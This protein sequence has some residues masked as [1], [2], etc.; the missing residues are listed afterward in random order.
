[1]DQL[2]PYRIEVTAHNKEWPRDVLVSLESPIADYICDSFSV[3]LRGFIARCRGATL[4]R[5]RSLKFLAGGTPLASCQINLPRPD[6][7]APKAKT[8]VDRRDSDCGFDTV[9]PSFLT[10]R[11]VPIEIRVEHE[12]DATGSSLEYRLVSIRFRSYGKRRKPRKCDDIGFVIVNSIGRSGSSLVCRVLDQ[13]AAC[14]TPRLGG[15]YGEVFILGHYLRAIGVLSS[16]GALA[17]LNKFEQVSDF[18]GLPVGYLR[19]DL[20][21]GDHEGELYKRIM[22]DTRRQS[23]RT[24]ASVFREIANYARATKPGAQYWVEK[25]WNWSTSNIAASLIKNYREVIVVRHIREFWRSQRLYHRKLRS[26]RSEVRRH[27]DG[28]FHKYIRLAE[29]CCDRRGNALVVRYEDLMSNP[30][31]QFGS[32]FKYLEV[33]YNNQLAKQVGRIARGNDPHHA[34]L[35]SSSSQKAQPDDFDEYLALLTDSERKYLDSALTELGYSMS[36]RAAAAD[37]KAEE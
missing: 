8:S 29:A 19:T 3:E 28:T 25:S 12:P 24:F 36:S 7:A 18:L 27:V 10:R 16:E 23:I 17:E 11:D 22:S 9:L 14:L 6:V 13:H 15:Q 26:S 37:R 31:E 34:L 21:Q 33:G 5:A 35:S 2:P 30:R 32:V 1:M 20:R 4:G